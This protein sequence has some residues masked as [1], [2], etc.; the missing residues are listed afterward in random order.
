MKNNN[1]QI[2]N[3]KY[4]ISNNLCTGCGLCEDTCP[5]KA[6]TIKIK[7]G[8]FIPHIDSSLCNNKKS[9]HKCYDI[10]PGIGIK[11]NQ[12]A[13]EKF[14]DDNIHYHN[15]IGYYQECFSGYSTNLNIRYHSASGGVLSQFLIWML[16]KKIITGAV[17]TSCD[18]KQKLLVHT[19]IAHTEEEILAARSSKYTSVSL[20]QIIQ[21]IKEENG[22]F[23]IVGLPCHIQ[24][25]RKYEKKDNK[26]KEKI[27]GYFGLY[28][29]YGRTFNLTEYVFKE[30]GIDQSSLK[31]FA[32]RDE[33]CLGSLVAEGINKQ[34]NK[35][36]KIVE[37]YQD[38]YH[39]LRSFF[40]PRRC[41]FCID[42]CSELADVSF[43]D[44]HI[45]PYIED[46]IGVNSL[47]VRNKT[48]LDFIKMARADKYLHLDTI[49]AET[50]VKSQ[51]VIYFK[52]MRT[53]T[54]LK[55]DK[56]FRHKVPIYDIQ[57]K[58]DKP[59]KS[60]IAYFITLIQIYIGGHKKLWFLIK[61]LKKKKIKD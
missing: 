1:P 39:P 43:G 25:F 20:N 44:I 12:I 42:H 6:I 4:T 34:K 29:S 53:A 19:Y 50:V 9:C 13:S 37:K 55:L 51:K 21:K 7:N 32:Y 45:P 47:I 41:L 11:L 35:S 16:Q 24:G 3:I 27:L 33:G 59:I 61:P 2:P 57:L 58:D 8:Q 15:L 30:R 52:K 14:S 40:I 49:S 28:C 38:Y 26:F 23:I 46:K 54:Y 17:V 36:F 60:I 18:P 31:Y 10:C 22:K 56:L 48:F 5:T